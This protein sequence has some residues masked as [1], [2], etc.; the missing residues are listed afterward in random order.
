[1]NYT[2]PDTHIYKRGTLPSESFIEK[3][4]TVTE[5]PT[6]LEALKD[7]PELTVKTH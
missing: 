3:P 6:E 2:M 1:M 5:P 7:S 4:C